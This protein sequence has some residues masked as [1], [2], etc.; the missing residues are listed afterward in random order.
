MGG[1]GVD[2]QLLDHL[3]TERPL[4]EHALHRE[5]HHALGAPGEEVL[6]RLLAEA[7]RVPRVA[8]VPLVGELPGR[9]REL[10]RVDH[11]DVVARV[12]VRCPR[13]LVLAAEQ[14]RDLGREPTQH[15][16]VG[17]DDVPGALDV[18]RLGLVGPHA[19]LEV[20]WKNGVDPR[21]EREPGRERT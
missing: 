17:V 9:D 6:E 10:G 8:V 7:S 13:R 5:T 12:Y 4:G 18:G 3:T 21:A 16:T 2:T 20:S 19:V 14:R 1:V 15:C 11:D